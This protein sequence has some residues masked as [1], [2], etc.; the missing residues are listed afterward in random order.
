MLL[1]ANESDSGMRAALGHG[2]QMAI[3]KAIL[4]Q[5]EILGGWSGGP[6]SGLI[7]QLGALQ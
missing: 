3:E 2:D 1:F 6:I 4:K 7:K 5:S